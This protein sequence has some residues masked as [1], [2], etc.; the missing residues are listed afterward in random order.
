MSSAIDGQIEQTVANLD[1]WLDTMRGPDGYGGPVSHWWQS[2]L[3]YTGA[4][5][6]WRYEGIIAGYLALHRRTGELRWLEKARAAGH[7]LLRGQLAN[8]TFYHSAFEL[9]PATGGTPHEA[10]CALALLELA[11]ALGRASADG[12]RFAAAAERNLRAYWIGRLW[13]ERAGGFRDGPATPS[14]VPNKAATLAEALLLLARLSGDES[15]ATGYALPA[16]DGVLAHQIRGGALDGAIAQNS[17]GAKRVAKY[18]PYYVARCLPGLIGGYEWSGERRYLEGALRAMAW[19]MRQRYD[20]GSFPQVVYPGG[21]ANR[22]PQWVAATGDILRALDAVRTYG[23]AWDVAPS[24]AWLLGG[25]QAR[26]G[27]ATAHG[28]AEQAWQRRPGPVAELRD[29]VPVCGW[30][31]KAF[32]Y[33]AGLVAEGQALPA[34]WVSDVEL[35][36]VTRRRHGVWRET[37]EELRLE[38]GGAPAYSWRKGEPWAATISREAL[39]K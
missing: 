34:V 9:N 25:R 7:D 26:G 35:P 12:A 33:L 10:A 28:F 11:A 30:A 8:G 32:R 27:I 13:D 4:G 15:L 21:R 3:H 24:L 6:D 19:V 31:D 1:H 2:C 38:I 23:Y 16:L 37:D 20:D 36:C 18:F 29:L 22:Y 39:W 14:F 17:F 5:L